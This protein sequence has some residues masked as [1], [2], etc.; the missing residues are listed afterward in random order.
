MPRI[1]L[2]GHLRMTKIPNMY[3]SDFGEFESAIRRLE[4]IFAKK[5]DDETMQAYWGALKDQSLLA[6]RKYV[7]RHERYGKFFPK[8]S[9]LRPKEEKL[10]VVSGGL[11]EVEDIA[12]KQ[13]EELR[14]IDLP[15]WLHRMGDRN[16]ARIVR[17]YGSDA[18]WFDMA[19]R[20]WRT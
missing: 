18:V 16:A 15:A 4:K 17:T 11:R 12:I 14:R 13:L 5:I 9:E 10:P 19:E 20:C 8:P 3:V 2:G 1:T 7:E 6:F